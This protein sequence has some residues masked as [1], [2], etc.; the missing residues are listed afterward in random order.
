[1]SLIRSLTIYLLRIKPDSPRITPP[2]V[3]ESG[4]NAF[5][6]FQAPWYAQTAF[7]KRDA[8]SLGHA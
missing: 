6:K 7:A 8:C 2:Q 5:I 1:M 3:F 4:K